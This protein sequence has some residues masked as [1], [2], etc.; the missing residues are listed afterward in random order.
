MGI[1]LP[2]LLLVLMASALLSV[3]VGAALLAVVMVLLAL[4]AL[5]FVLLA[6]GVLLVRLAADCP[7]FGFGMVLVWYGLGLHAWP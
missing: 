3:A 6:L 5:D 4:E 2:A 7:W 1:F